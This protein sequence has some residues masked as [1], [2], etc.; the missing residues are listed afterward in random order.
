LQF[1]APNGSVLAVSERFDDKCTAATATTELRDCAGTGL[2]KDH[3]QKTTTM[4]M[5]KPDLAVELEDLMLNNAKLDDFVESLT[6]VDANTVNGES[7]DTA[8][9][10]TISRRKKHP[11][12]AWRAPLARSLDQLEDRLKQGPSLTAMTEQRTVQACDLPGDD[13]WPRLAGPATERSIRSCLSIPLEVQGPSRAVMTLAGVR[14]DAFSP[15]DIYAAE[16]FAKQASKVLRAALWITELTETVQD[17]YS[18]LEHRTVID[19]ALGVVMGQNHCGHDTA[20]NILRR[21]VSSRNVKLRDLA[22]SVVK[23]ASGDTRIIVHFD[24]RRFLDDGKSACRSTNAG[25]TR[26]LVAVLSRAGPPWPQGPSPAPDLRSPAELLPCGR[27]KAQSWLAGDARTLVTAVSILFHRRCS[28]AP[29]E[30]QE[31]PSAPSR[32]VR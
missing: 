27:E 32:I 31:R 17:L 5:P 20:F 26:K 25:H 22:A 19:S 4:V 7:P 8:C 9:C 14:S 13:R 1:L 10:I 18:A 24:P 29:E 30:A 3:S 6:T 23:S 16:A 2:I 15:N 11:I 21:A 12:K 28:G